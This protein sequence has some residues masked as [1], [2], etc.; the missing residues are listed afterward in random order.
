MIV[1]DFFVVKANN[2][3][4]SGDPEMQEAVTLIA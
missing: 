1:P 4:N 3:P 2:H